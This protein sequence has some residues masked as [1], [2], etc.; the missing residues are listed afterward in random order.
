MCVSACVE[1]HAEGETPVILDSSGRYRIEYEDTLRAIGHY[2]DVNL[3]H[4][5]TIVE[6]P[7]GLLAKGTTSRV[8]H[9]ST[10]KTFRTYLFTDDEI[11]R[12][13]EDAYARRGR[14]LASTPA[15]KELKVSNQD[16]LRLVGRVIDEEA[17][18]DV[19]I[20]QVPDGVRIKALV[21]AQANVSEGNQQIDSFMSDSQIK[22]WAGELRAGRR[23]IRAAQLTGGDGRPLVR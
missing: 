5:I 10:R 4:N 11:G 15:T 8:A 9:L 6:L 21:R 1:R 16:L 23:P 14:E 22:R 20:T 18:H 19:V 7:E 12:I 13:L 17:W 2:L 3:Y